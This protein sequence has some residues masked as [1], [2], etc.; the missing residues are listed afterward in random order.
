[1]DDLKIKRSLGEGSF[2]QVF[3]VRSCVCMHE[4]EREAHRVAR[5]ASTALACGRCA[6]RHHFAARASRS[7]IEASRALADDRA[8]PATNHQ[9]TLGSASGTEDRVVL[10]RVKARVDVR[11]SA[12]PLAFAPPKHAQHPIFLR[13]RTSCGGARA[14]A[15]SA[16]V[17]APAPTHPRNQTAQHTLS[18]Q[19]Q[20]LQRQPTPQHRAP[21]R[22]R[23][24]S[25]SSTCT[26]RASRAAASPSF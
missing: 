19:R 16:P 12:A 2:G 21:T 7:P 11:P 5:T 20:H 6:V 4:R 3:E 10:K 24:W 18:Q 26:P 17:P 13:A 9:G 14:V 15:R 25:T 1:V 8:H 22:W 23:A